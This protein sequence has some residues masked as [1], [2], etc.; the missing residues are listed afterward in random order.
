MRHH[1]AQRHCHYLHT[2]YAGTNNSEG[3]I[4]HKN[5]SGDPVYIVDVVD[6]A[7]DHILLP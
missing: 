2:S 4:G 3:N 7:K 6:F 5:L 1:Q